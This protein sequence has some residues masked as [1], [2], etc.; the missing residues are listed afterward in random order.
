MFTSLTPPANG[1]PAN[2]LI[3]KLAPDLSNIS[4]D[5]AAVIVEPIITDDSAERIKWLEDLR[6][7]CDQAG[8]VLIFDEIITGFRFNKYSVSKTY[9]I[10][11]DLLCLGKAMGS[12]IP[13]ACVAGDASLMDGD[14]FVSSTNAGSVAGLAACIETIN[15]LTGVPDYDVEKLWKSGGY[16]IREFNKL[17][18]NIQIEGYHTRGV[19]KGDDLVKALFFQECCKSGVLFGPSFF[20]NFDHIRQSEVV[21]EICKS[22]LERIKEVTLIGSLPKKPIAERVRT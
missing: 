1:V 4:K 5:I 16:F 8:A 2:V 6:W 20:F 7:K 19:F 14:Y 11:P 22:I 12:G 10:Y 13:I 21:L 9:K 3:S 17:N 18:Q 15:M